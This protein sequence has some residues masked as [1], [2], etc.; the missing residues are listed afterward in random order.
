MADYAL[1]TIA[2][3]EFKVTSVGS[4]LPGAADLVL[5]DGVRQLD[6][7]RATWEAM[8]GAA[9]ARRNTGAGRDRR[10]SE[11]D[12]PPAETTYPGPR[13]PHSVTAEHKLRY[14]SAQGWG[15]H[16]CKYRLVS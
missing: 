5:S 12:K 3:Q 6:P 8:L 14:T 16:G 7:E 2:G 15:R 4:G 1:F 11:A 13:D 10:R 9:A